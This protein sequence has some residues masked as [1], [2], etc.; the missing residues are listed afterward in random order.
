M[1]MFYGTLKKQFFDRTNRFRVPA[2]CVCGPKQRPK[3]PTV[4]MGVV[5]RRG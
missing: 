5:V 4:V 3:E 1:S 2:A